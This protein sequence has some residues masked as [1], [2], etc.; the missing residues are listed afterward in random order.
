MSE[1]VFDRSA[2]VRSASGDEAL[3][4][5]LIRLFLAE[6]G[7]LAVRI[8]AATEAA[9]RAELRAAAH[10]LRGSAGIVG[11]KRLRAACA[12]LEERTAAAPD[13]IRRLVARLI[14]ANH[15]ACRAMS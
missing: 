13:E 1:P 8:E 5:E 7:G 6:A 10:R 12:D 4:A 3:G 15:E 14:S 11:A 9:D 2:L